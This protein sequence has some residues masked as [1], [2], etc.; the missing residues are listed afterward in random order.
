MKMQN[1]SVSVLA[2]GSFEQDRPLLRDIF[3]NIGWTLLEASDRRRAMQHLQRQPVHVVIAESNLPQW[4]WKKVLADLRRMAEPPQLIVA[5]R[6][7][8]DYLWSEVLN[9]GG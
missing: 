1:H 8:D 7:A 3:G 9:L 6:T 5:S 4:S 2:I